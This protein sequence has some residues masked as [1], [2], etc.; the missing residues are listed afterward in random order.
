MRVPGK[1][2]LEEDVWRGAG[3][4]ERAKAA[5][6]QRIRDPRLEQG[7]DRWLNADCRLRQDTVGMMRMQTQ[8]AIVLRSGIGIMVVRQRQCLP[9]QQHEHQQQAGMQQGPVVRCE[10]HEA[11]KIYCC[12]PA[13]NQ[14][15]ALPRRA[16]KIGG[17]IDISEILAAIGKVDLP[18]A[19]LLHPGHY[20][21][22]A[23]FQV[24]EQ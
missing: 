23:G 7:V 2:G 6:K 16:V 15:A 22:L 19:D 20:T 17:L 9:E 14:L 5:G 21:A 1:N 8:R 12:R 13:V 24:I 4:V 11:R 18:C 10:L 3:L